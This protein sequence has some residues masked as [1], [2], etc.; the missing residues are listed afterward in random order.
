MIPTSTPMPSIPIDQNIIQQ[1]NGNLVT[2]F[3]VFIIAAVLYLVIS[4]IWHRI[5]YGERAG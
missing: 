5:K 3:V 4:A 1:A 2:I